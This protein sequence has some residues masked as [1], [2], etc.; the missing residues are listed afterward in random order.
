M[1]AIVL[2]GGRG[3]RLGL[4]G[5]PKALVPLAGMPLLDRTI[6]T[7]VEHG[8]HDFLVMTGH[9]GDVLEERLGRG[10][11]FGARIDY[12]REETPLGTAG[13][14]NLIRDRLTEPFLVIYGDVLMDVDLQAFAAVAA[15]NGGIGT[16][17]A[18]PND[19]PFDSDLLEV[20]NGDRI[21]RVLPKP[22]A[23]GSHHA[24]L[25]SAALYVLSPAA[26]DYVPR[27]GLSDWGRDVLPALAKAEALFAYRS[28][29][30]IKDMGTPERLAKGERHL[31]ERRLGRL[32]LRT[33]KKALF[34]DRDGVINVE[35]D[36]VHT[37]DQVELIPGVAA[38]IRQFNDAAIP[39]ICVTNQPDLAKGFMS[40]DDLN[41]VSGMIDHLLAKEAGAYLDDLLVCPHHPEKGW[42]GEVAALKIDCECRKPGPGLL[43]EA[44]KRHNIDLAGS[45]LVGDRFCDVAAANAAGAKAVLVRTG[46]AGND[47]AKFDNVPDRGFSDFAA[48]APFLLEQLA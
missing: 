48:A 5:I 2:A 15:R 39:V 45:W 26:L 38:A 12:V 35:R 19:H 46:H 33:R 24:N 6:T 27:E 7:A 36:G 25:V 4:G 37:A 18:H 28:V 43:N 23:P 17:F 42:P 14:F 41:D 10:E 3:T 47:S 13:C 11:R 44:S 30:Y 32:A 16:L 20:G 1:K 9:L 21:L 29:E 8:V 22:H 31:A 40:T 34:L